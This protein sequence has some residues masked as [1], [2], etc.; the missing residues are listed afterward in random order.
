[1]SNVAALI[2]TLLAIVFVHDNQQLEQKTLVILFLLCCHLLSITFTP[3]KISPKKNYTIIS[4]IGLA[5]ITVYLWQNLM[6]SAIATIATLVLAFFSTE[7]NSSSKKIMTCYAVAILLL[8]LLARIFFNSGS[9]EIISYILL[10]PF[11]GLLPFQSWYLRFFSEA[12]LGVIASFVSFQSII[13]LTITNLTKFQEPAL[14]QWLLALAITTSSILAV[15]QQQTRKC[16]AYLVTSQIGFLAFACLGINQ[17]S[18]PGALFMALSIIGA[19]SGFLMMVSAVEMRKS[20]ISLLRPS[21]CYES[22]P[23]LSYWLLTFSLIA[24]GL[25]LSIGYV[26]EDLIFENNFNSAPILDFIYLLSIAI[27]TIVVI[28][29][30]LFLCQGTHQKEDDLDL[31]KSEIVINTFVLFALVLATILLT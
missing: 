31:R 23:K 21:G 19:T 11:I 28:K 27:N 17:E 9:K 2:A 1:M 26:A 6:I 8:V 4:L 20:N 25:P 7:Q 14:L 18:N 29:I 5:S 16:L 10:F 22:Y 13:I 24:C 30:F 3:I 12:S 15:I